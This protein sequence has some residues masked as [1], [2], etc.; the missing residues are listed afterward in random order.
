M[1]IVESLVQNG[2]DVNEVHDR[3]ITPLMI[4]ASNGRKDVVSYLI[5]RGAN[6]KWKVSE[7]YGPP[8]T[9]LGAAQAQHYTDVV[10][11]LKKAGAK[12]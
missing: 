5:S 9:A 11:I 3:Y 2:A 4:A 10:N 6:V 7:K 12:E 1:D 8:F